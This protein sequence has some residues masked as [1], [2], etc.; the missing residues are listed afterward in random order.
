MP[1]REIRLRKRYFRMFEPSYYALNEYEKVSYSARI[2]NIYFK[3]ADNELMMKEKEEK[4]LL[5]KI[6][7]SF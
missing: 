6:M 5:D 2:D 1:K 3:R 7:S 4:Q